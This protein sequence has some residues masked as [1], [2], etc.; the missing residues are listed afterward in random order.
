M[1]QSTSQFQVCKPLTSDHRRA[2]RWFSSLTQAVERPV[3]TRAPSEPSL[4]H[5]IQFYGVYAE[6]GDERYLSL[7]ENFLKYTLQV[8]KA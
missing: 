5:S 6:T 7:C 4:Q 8:T 1:R 3:E 2:I